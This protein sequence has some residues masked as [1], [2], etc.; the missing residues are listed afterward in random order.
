MERFSGLVWRFIPSLFKEMEV[1][2]EKSRAEA[3]RSGQEAVPSL[4]STAA[5]GGDTEG[6]GESRLARA[7]LKISPRPA[8]CLGL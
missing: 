6:S 7:K 3:A 5:C 1:G 4:P 2:G 8:R